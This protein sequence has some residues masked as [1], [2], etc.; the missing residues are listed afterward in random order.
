MVSSVRRTAEAV[1]SGG[2]LDGI[3]TLERASGAA[4]E[5][6]GWR[7]RT[8]EGAI[9]T[10][11]EELVA[12]AH[13]GSMAMAVAKV[14][15]E[16]GTPAQR[17]VVQSSCRLDLTEFGTGRIARLDVRVEGRAPGVEP[18]AFD[19]LVQGADAAC[20]VANALRGNVAIQVTAALDQPPGA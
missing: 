13:A 2:L 3:G 18:D 20:P 6:I 1:W 15:G 5:P 19:E 17:L 10:T 7:D 14:L 11:P 8:A 12:A 4:A 16:N 9:G